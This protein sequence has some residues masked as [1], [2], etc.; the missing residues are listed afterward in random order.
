MN[1]AELIKQA[2]PASRPDTKKLV[3]VAKTTVQS[4]AIPKAVVRPATVKKDDAW[5]QHLTTVANER[6]GHKP[7]FGDATIEFKVGKSGET[8]VSLTPYLVYPDGTKKKPPYRASAGFC[9][10]KAFEPWFE[11][12]EK[13]L[14]DAHAA[15]APAPKTESILRQSVTHWTGEIEKATQGLD[16]E[17]ETQVVSGK[18]TIRYKGASVTLE[19]ATDGTLSVARGN[20]PREAFEKILRVFA[21]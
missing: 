1:L 3:E 5:V 17:I 15:V 2:A 7:E 11:G 9:T 10:T 14:V 20:G 4:E 18:L 12:L 16:N 6:F 8:M 19:K 13:L 21:S